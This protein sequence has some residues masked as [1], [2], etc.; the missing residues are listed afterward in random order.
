M[1]G[2]DFLEYLQKGNPVTPAIGHTLDEYD[3][4][5]VN[6]LAG[7]LLY[8]AALNNL[9][10]PFGGEDTRQ[11]MVR[12]FETGGHSATMKEYRTR[13]GGAKSFAL[14]LLLD[15][16]NLL[17]VA[18]APKALIQ[19]GKLA[20]VAERV[21][22][23]AQAAEGLYR[24]ANIGDRVMAAPV[25]VPIRGIGAVRGRIGQP[26]VL[27]A[28][29]RTP[30]QG[31]SAVPRPPTSVARQPTTRSA[32]RP[33]LESSAGS[34]TPP[35]ERVGLLEF[36]GDLTQYTPEELRRRAAEWDELDKKWLMAGGREK[37][38][39]L[40]T[41]MPVSY[42]FFRQMAPWE[43]HVS[44]WL[45]RQPEIPRHPAVPTQGLRQ[46]IPAK[47]LLV[48]PYGTL[49]P[50]VHQEMAQSNYVQILGTWLHRA[51]DMLADAV[52]KT[53]LLRD[54]RSN[55]SH[56]GGL[57]ASVERA[58]VNAGRVNLRTRREYNS[59][60][61]S[62][63][64]SFGDAL[65]RQ[66]PDVAQADLSKVNRAV[67]A[68]DMAEDMVYTL[69][70]ELV[71][72]TYRMEDG[73]F[74]QA[75]RAVVRELRP[76]KRDLTAEL[77]GYLQGV[78]DKEMEPLYTHY[79]TVRGAGPS[80]MGDY[81]GEGYAAQFYSEREIARRGAG[82]GGEGGLLPTEGG[83]VS[84]S[85]GTTRGFAG[86]EG[87]LQG[88]SGGGVGRSPDLQRGTR[89][90]HSS[91]QAGPANVGGVVG[92]TAPS[93]RAVAQPTSAPNWVTLQRSRDVATERS[94]A[95]SPAKA[96][97]QTARQQALLRRWQN[98]APEVQERM[99]KNP[100]VREAVMQN[101]SRELARIRQ[102]DAPWGK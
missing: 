15:P 11:A 72:N 89:A 36:L 20:T 54:Y 78:V 70:H 58:G 10:A 49:P 47:P 38:P 62:P 69:L 53:S 6:R 55:P 39:H 95:P 24:G 60:F 29:S 92:G 13:E 97:L 3:E 91:W 41:G 21:P 61:V 65:A 64:G 73:P 99:W 26:A 86:P 84:P 34:Q 96:Q 80:D 31:A 9:F 19:T 102:G 94:L 52:P 75:L 37:W 56:F 16:L 77:D 33:A 32:A 30:E 44:E 74:A 98:A 23:L 8:Q 79:R 59:I 68:R 7:G 90:D 27:K 43:R 81:L 40:D 1:A 28:S 50:A 67:L 48:D 93:L 87:L 66:V 100:E 35:G 45:A 57:E 51:H 22:G 101:L 85:P 2:F 5:V 46:E 82:G 4:N 42:F 63:W 76:V 83:H 18:K 25:A 88:A 17:P 12:A 71:H 14:Q